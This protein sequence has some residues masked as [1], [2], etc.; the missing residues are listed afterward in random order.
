MAMNYVQPG[1]TITLIA[2][3]AVAAGAGVLVGALFG[4]ALS[5]AAQG[6]P[7]ECRHEDVFDLAKATGQAWTQGAKI[8]W[9]NTAFNCTTSASGTTL[10]GAAMQAQASG[11]IVGRVL[12]TGQLV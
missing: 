8:Y 5:P 7:V 9:D 10:I 3:R 6:A 1:D 11:D 2:P 12:L 4:V